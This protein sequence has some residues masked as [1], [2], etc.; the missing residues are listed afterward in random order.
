MDVDVFEDALFTVFEHH[1]P[2]RGDPGTTGTYTNE[3]IPPDAHGRRSITYRIPEVSNENTR[4][5]AHHQWDAGV[6]VTDLRA[7]YDPVDVRGKRVIE[8]GAGT[9]LPSLA[10]AVLGAQHVRFAALLPPLRQVPMEDVN[11]QLTQTYLSAS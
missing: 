10:C 9:G 4:L 1:Q 11:G 5:F 2:A 7:S 8:L 3:A 6:H